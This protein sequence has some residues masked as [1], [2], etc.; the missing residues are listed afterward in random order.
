MRD[1]LRKSFSVLTVAATIVYSVGLTAFVPTASAAVASGSLIKAS[2]AAVY[3]MG[4]DGKRYVFPDQKTYFTWYGDFSSV[5]TITDAELASITIGGNVT[6]RPGAK[7]GKINTDPKV[8]AISAHG[9]LRPIA[10]EAVAAAI[11]GAAWATMV[12]D[13]SDAFFTNYTI[14]AAINSAADYDRAA[15]LAAATS[16]NVDKQLTGVIPPSPILTG[17]AVTVSLASDSPVS[18]VVPTASSIEMLKVKLMTGSQSAQIS[19]IMLTSSGLGAALNIDSVTL[20]DGNGVKIANAKNVTSDKQVSFSFATPLAIAANSTYTISARATLAAGG[21]YALGIAAATDIVAGGTIAG[22]FPITGSTMNATGTVAVGTVALTTP[23]TS[24]TLHDFGEDNVLLADLTLSPD[25][26]EDV[27]WTSASFKNGGTNTADI[28]SNLKLIADGVEIATGTYANGYVSFTINNYLIQK[29][30]SVSVE[31][32]GDLGTV[33]SGDTVK[34]YIKDQADLSFTGVG[35]GYGVQ[36]TTAGWNNLDTTT[37][38]QII[39]MQTGQFSIDFDKALTPSK[40]VKTDTLN[41]VL[42]TLKLKSNGENATI[43]GFADGASPTTQF[44]VGGTAVDANDLINFELVDLATGGVLSITD[45]FAA[46]VYNLSVDDEISLVAGVQKSYQL[47]ADVT[48]TADVLDTYQVTLDAAALTVTGDISNATIA[49]ITPSSITSAVTTVKDAT[50]EY[51]AVPLTNTTVVPGAQDVVIFQGILKAGNADGI[52][53]NSL[54]LSALEEDNNADGNATN[55]FVFTDTNISQL[56][57]YLNGVLL[58]SLSNSIVEATGTGSVGARTASITFNSLS[59]VNNA[60]VIAANA[61]VPVVVKAR[62]A[63]SLTVSGPLADSFRTSVVV[64]GDIVARAV[65]SNDSVVATSTTFGTAS[66]NVSLASVGSLAVQLKTTGVKVADTNLLAGAS[67]TANRYLAELVFS[68]A[69]EPIKVTEIRLEQTGTATG[70]DLNAIKLVDGAGVVKATA[71]PAANGDAIFDNLSLVMDADKATS[72]YVSVDSKG[73]NVDGVPSSTAT[74]ANV[75]TFAL[76]AVDGVVAEGVNTSTTITMVVDAG[77]NADVAGPVVAGN[78]EFGEWTVNATNSKIS[79][80]RTVTMT[81]VVNALS[82]GTLQGGNDKIIGKF[83]ITANNAAVTGQPNRLTDNT[84]AE[85]VLNAITL[86]TSAAAGVTLSDVKMYVEGFSSNTATASTQ[87]TGNGV[88]CVWNAAA[89]LNL[90]NAGSFVG[91][92]TIVITA[93]VTT[94]SGEYLQLSLDNLAGGDLTY[95][96]NGATVADLLLGYTSVSGGSLNN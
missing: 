82:N 19:S 50:L 96:S 84:A 83:T 37:E 9:V 67:T 59:T 56:D 15:E 79:N 1:L 70:A 29:S 17:G 92:E 64:T 16:I 71:I 25:A 43:T 51:S 20:F 75:V 90:I 22:S 27:L 46:G 74:E 4:A 11:Y 69:N 6:Y 14:G 42:A 94:S 40:D 33:N 36:L 65:V 66:R 41:V 89:L 10:S 62:Y 55:N 35:Y 49:N 86:S 30:D 44:E 61:T 76:A 31:V 38:A 24:N 39:T 80:I 12:Q 73:I 95:L 81:N 21:Y 52:K 26:T 3:Y 72:L 32:R 53:L 5:I 57:L 58:K 93:D 63:S 7:M 48:S 87:C 88:D 77:T 18:Q 8:Y 54:Q 47:R 68:T 28:I 78:L 2:G 60:N 85:A 34:L 91:T 45:T 13:I 23:A